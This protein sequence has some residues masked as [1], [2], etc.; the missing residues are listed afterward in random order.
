MLFTIHYSLFTFL[1][2]LTLPATSFALS[3]IADYPYKSSIELLESRGVIDG[4]DDGTFRPNSAI[5]RAEFLKLLMLAAFGS[6][7]SATGDN[8]CFIDFVQQEKWFWAHACGAKD[9]G[10]IHGH[11]DG[12]FRGT[13]TIILAEALKMAFEAWEIPLPYDPAFTQWYEPYMYG[14]AER[15]VFQRFP[16]TPDYQLTRGEMALLLVMIGDSIAFVSEEPEYF[17][18]PEQTQPSV[19]GNGTVE[20]GEQCDDGNKEDGD[21]C[22]SICVVVAEP[23]RHG[24][25]RIEQQRVSNTPQTSGNRDVPMFAFTAIAGRQDVYL[26]TVKLKAVA[27]SLTSTEN[28]RIIIDKD[29]NGNVETLYG[30]GTKA[31]DTVIFSNLNILVKDG[32]YMSIEIWADLDTSMNPDSVTIGFDTSQ[33]DFIEGIGRIDGEEV[34]GIRLNSDDCTLQTICWVLVITDT[35]QEIVIRANGN[36]Y[37]TEGGPL[38]SRQVL[39]STT[40]QGLLHLDLRA[41]SENVIIK[42]LAIEGVSSSVD[43]LELYFEG[44]NTPFTTARKIACS[45]IATG[46]FCTED[47]FRIDKDQEKSIIVRASMLSDQFGAVSNQSMTLVVSA[48]TSGNVAMSAQG[49]YSG[50]QLLQ[51]NGDATADG[52]VFIGTESPAA[53]SSI[54]GPTH[55]VTLA[56][57]ASIE[58]ANTDAEGSAIPVGGQKIA[59]FAFNAATHSNSA[60]DLNAVGIDKLTFTVSAV[61][62]QFDST[63]FALYHSENSGST[64]PCTASGDTGTITV[65]CSS[66]LA[67]PVS[68]VISQGGTLDLALRGNVTNAQV[69]GG[70]SILQVSLNSLSNPSETGTVEWT[71]SVS[72]FDWVDLSGKTTVKSTTYRTQ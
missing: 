71:D 60:G 50:Q 65:T 72:T 15:N 9:R 11:P 28:Y 12:T 7:Q 30:R 40:S 23:I 13:D 33:S 24:A 59:Q 44:Q 62:I 63:S 19:C 54:V 37:L 57:I 67:S 35:D 5:N 29:G 8:R 69:G 64:S 38:S 31:G 26:T 43:Y 14:A 18:L 45:P 10:I 36:V 49:V 41:D 17:T 6:S 47:E 48:V 4:Y 22:S 55:T 52:E 46:R 2:A 42:Q 32:R 70:T 21:G 56:K 53:N 61:N 25:L 20:K 68:T 3:D 51:N 58:N 66:L 34:R 27:G 16:F 1:V 39:A